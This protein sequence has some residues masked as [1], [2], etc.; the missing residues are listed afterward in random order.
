MILSVVLAIG[1]AVMFAVSTVAQQR[2]AAESSDA[3]ARQGRFVGQLLRNPRWLGS[4]GIN[5]L[6]FV[7]QAAAL[8][9]G[10]VLVVAP[11][12]AASLVFALPLGAALDRRR[13]PRRAV[14]AAVVLVG[15]L[16]VFVVLANPTAGAQHG[17]ARGWLIATVGAALVVVPCIVIAN[18]RSGATRAS[19]LAVPVG[20]LGGA[21]S[22]LTKAVVD[23]LP[24]GPGTV[25]TTPETYGLIV[26]G[27]GGTYLQSLA[28]QAGNLQA[29]LPVLTVLEPLVAAGLGLALLHEELDATGARLLVLLVAVAVL[30]V[31]TVALAREHAQQVTGKSAFV[32][33]PSATPR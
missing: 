16:V 9:T 3:D 28:F 4:I 26:V 13:L 12:L 1:A 7:L 20:V 11:I 2:A 19:L 32:D 8:G 18:R 31:A 15:A 27:V 24:D 22:V 29:S 14:I 5:A 17:S 25:L 33:R 6:A 30:A 10:S 23:A 21:L